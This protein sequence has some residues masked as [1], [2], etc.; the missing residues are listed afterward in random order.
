MAEPGLHR[1]YVDAGTQ[2]AGC[3]GIAETVQV[4]LGVIQ[5]RSFRDV[6]AE[7]VQEP[8]ACE[9][10]VVLRRGEHERAILC[11]LVAPQDG[12]YFGYYAE[13]SQVSY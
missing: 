13:A 8:V 5:L 6:L 12:H 7:V 2:P 10:A 11:P 9:L 4:S 3:G 1:P